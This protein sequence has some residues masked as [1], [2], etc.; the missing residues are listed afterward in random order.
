MEGVHLL[1]CREKYIKSPELYPKYLGDGQQAP[2][3][4]LPGEEVG[5]TGGFIDLTEPIPFAVRK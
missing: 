4:A 5:K 2:G 3:S 1:H